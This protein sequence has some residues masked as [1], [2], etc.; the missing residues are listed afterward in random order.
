MPDVRPA[1]VHLHDQEPRFFLPPSLAQTFDLVALSPA[2]LVTYSREPVA[3]VVETDSLTQRLSEQI[4][5]FI[6][7]T[8]NPAVC[9]ICDTT[10]EAM[11]QALCLCTQ[12]VRYTSSQITDDKTRIDNDLE[13]LFLS[14][15]GQKRY[16]HALKIRSHR[17]GLVD[18]LGIVAHQWRQPI[19]LISMEAINLLIQTNIEEHLNSSSVSKSAQI[20]SDQAQRMSEILKS[21]LNL[22]KTR[23][24]K[25][26]FTLSRLFE[27]IDSLW[28]E[29]LRYHGI[30]LEIA[31]V[32]GERQ[33]YGYPVDI[34]EV[35]INLIANA[36]DA[37]LSS[38]KAGEKTITISL[39]T[40]A[41]HHCISVMDEAGGVPELLREKIFQ[42]NFSTKNKEEGF[43]IGLHVARLIIEQEF[44]GTLI[45]KARPKGSEFVVTLPRNDLCDLT[46][47][48]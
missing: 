46:F 21:V 32:S 45:L 8:G 6:S 9:L 4:V 19:N 34:E 15:W 16:N 3:I 20:I 1:I 10:D 17:S 28:N 25:E 5:P 7:R 39:Q 37:Y 35:L 18:S 33:I 41:E 47:I 42:P 29:Q 31:P 12:T 36:R 22:G 38:G 48:D 13:K 27:E 24:A 44:H 2:E 14:L 23:R 40:D 11:L 43:G 30:T 26:L